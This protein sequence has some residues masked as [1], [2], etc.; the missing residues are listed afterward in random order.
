M[1][2]LLLCLFLCFAGTSFSEE[3]V[4]SYPDQH[5]VS[6]TQKNLEPVFP[7]EELIKKPN[8][9]DDKFYSEFINMLAS[10]GLIIALIFIVAWFLKRLANTR[11]TQV[12]NS[13]SIRIIEKRIISPKTSLF[14]LDIEGT[15]VFIAES[16]NGV[17]RLAEFS[18]KEEAKQSSSFEKLLESNPKK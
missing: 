17:T 2:K 13:S 7:I 16:A 11:L 3:S 12:N 15:T 10:L 1:M 14:L 8:K 6:L 4:P 18:T 5:S 9:Q